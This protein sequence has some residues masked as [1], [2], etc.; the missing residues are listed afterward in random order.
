LKHTNKGQYASFALKSVSKEVNRKFAERNLKI[1]KLQGAKQN[2]YFARDKD[3][4]TLL[5]I[6]K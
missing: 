6:S 4:L 1:I 3:L 5:I 2:V